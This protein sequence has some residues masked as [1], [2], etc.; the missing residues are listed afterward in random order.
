[1]PYHTNSV[2]IVNIR[3]R[4]KRCACGERWIEVKC[5][6]V[7]ILSMCVSVMP[8]GTDW[9]AWGKDDPWTESPSPH[10]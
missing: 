6:G 4:P 3:F 2:G 10:S 1:M 5:N 7:M 8:E 9:F